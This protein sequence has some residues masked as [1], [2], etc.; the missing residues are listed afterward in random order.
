MTTLLTLRLITWPHA[1]PLSAYLTANLIGSSSKKLKMLYN[2]ITPVH[3]QPIA[4][5]LANFHVNIADITVA[6]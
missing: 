3:P 5:I 6:N 4:A 1:L 2:H